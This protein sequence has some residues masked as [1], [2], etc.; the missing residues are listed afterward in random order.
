MPRSSTDS[1]ER[2]G[3][4]VVISGPSGVGKSTVVD[5]LRRRR[6][7]SFSVSATTRPARPG[8]RDGVDYH[9]LD[10]ETFERWRDAG[11]FLEWAEYGGHLYGTP[12]GPVEAALA[13]GRD[14]ILDIENQGALQVKAALPE[15]VTI[16]LLPPD[17]D[18]LEARLRGRRDTPTEEV[19][20]RLAV[21]DDQIAEARVTYDWLVTNEDVDSAMERIDRILEAS[22][23]TP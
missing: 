15:A 3:L 11:E 4:L 23:R 6:P 18:E 17:R 12:R 22:E 9:F 13:D 19:E 20:R 2:R 21:A 1:A 16:F 8:E 5:A 7:L 10:R 14:L